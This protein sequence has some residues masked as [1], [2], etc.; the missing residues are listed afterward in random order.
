MAELLT[1]MIG[2]LPGVHAP[3]CAPDAKHTYWKYPLRIDP[4]VSGA[5]PTRWARS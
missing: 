3:T 4:D 2:D 1:R 5:A